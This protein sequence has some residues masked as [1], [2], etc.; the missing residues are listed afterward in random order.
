MCR[1]ALTS[2]R[3]ELQKVKQSAQTA[4]LKKRK[5]Y[6]RGAQAKATW[7]IPFAD[8]FNSYDSLPASSVLPFA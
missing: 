6:I 2:S 7:V 4:F 8:F 3:I 1:K 5:A